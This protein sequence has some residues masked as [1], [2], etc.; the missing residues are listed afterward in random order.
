MQ[1]IGKD[2][3][4][5]YGISGDYMQVLTLYLDGVESR[6]VLAESG[7]M[8][9]FK[10]DV[11]MEKNVLESSGSFD[12]HVFSTFEKIVKH[13]KI[14]FTSYSGSGEV[15]FSNILPGMIQPVKLDGTSLIIAKDSLMAAIGTVDI[16]VL[17]QQGVGSIFFGGEGLVLTSVKGGGDVFI[18]GGG[19]IISYKLAG[20]ESIRVEGGSAIAWDSS[21]THK[22][23]R[24]AK[25]KSALFGDES[26][27][28]NTFTGPGTVLVQTIT[29]SKLKG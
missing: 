6:K 22:V 4:G 28:I 24:E 12:R 17:M 27:F 8:V 29:L 9:Y 19:T 13:E 10:G 16:S 26:L 1:L 2:Q 5:Y 7:T 21:V 14:A 3:E 15:G 18:S 20:G 23:E 11:K 25:L